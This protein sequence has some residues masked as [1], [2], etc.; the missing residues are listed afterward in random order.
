MARKILVLYYAATALFVSLDYGFGVNVRVAFLD[1]MPGVRAL[2]YVICF[3]CLVL[4]TWRPAWTT[5]VGT[6][7]SLVTLVALIV[8]MGM[9]AMLVTDT[10]LETGTGF[11][12]MEEIF[13]F[14]IA[15][16]VAYISYFVGVRA[17][18]SERALTPTSRSGFD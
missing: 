18:S 17:L 16:G 6:V 5:I 1:A 8:N 3:G 12:T 15:G 14:M 7:E 2:Y 13:N 11:I 9:R 10:M 4:M